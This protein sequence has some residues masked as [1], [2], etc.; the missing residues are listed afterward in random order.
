MADG[1]MEELM[2]EW[3]GLDGIEGEGGGKKNDDEQNPY[4]SWKQ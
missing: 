2:V 1:G 4:K 3:K